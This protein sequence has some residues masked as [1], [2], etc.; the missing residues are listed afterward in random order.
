MS[1]RDRSVTVGGWSLIFAAVLFMAVFGYLARA[2]NYPAV[3]DGQAAEVLPRLLALSPTGRT[4]WALYGIIP[5]LL[6][7]ASLGAW[8]ALAPRAP[9]LMRTAVVFA[10]FAAGAM[11][12]GLLRWPSIQWV[13][14]THYAAADASGRAAIAGVFDGLN[15]YLGNYLGEFVG[16][17]ALNL[18]FL[19]TA[20]GF[21]KDDAYPRWVGTAG[22]IAAGAG[23][24]AMWR[25]VTPAVAFVADV[26]NYMLPVWMI[27]MGWVL[28]RGPNGSPGAA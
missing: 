9:A 13:L 12:I 15:S 8:T 16:E 22:V 20:L 2:F 23:F 19:L 27:V 21:R 18:F 6:I 26:E 7:P 5:L 3:L 14:A 1:T 11:M 4:V 28:L 24:I 10:T 25:N 17:L